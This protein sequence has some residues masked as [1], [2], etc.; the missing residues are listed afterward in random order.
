MDID[1]DD[2]ERGWVDG[3]ETIA[4]VGAVGTGV[5]MLV[6]PVFFADERDLLDFDFAALF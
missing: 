4:P 2:G 6:V 1:V 3:G 5:L